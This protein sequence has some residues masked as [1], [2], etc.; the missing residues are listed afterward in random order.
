MLKQLDASQGI[1]VQDTKKDTS[2]TKNV[3]TLKK[4]EAAVKTGMIMSNSLN[5]QLDIVTQI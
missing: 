5:I 3:D 4:S 1:S 2:S